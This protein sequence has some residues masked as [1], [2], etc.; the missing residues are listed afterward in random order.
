MGVLKHFSDVV[1][2]PIIVVHSLND[3]PCW[4]PT[5]EGQKR[6]KGGVARITIQPCGVSWLGFS[7]TFS[8]RK[9]YFCRLRLE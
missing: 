4:P 6:V 7:G 2:G 8:A 3:I 1:C 9:H 5:P